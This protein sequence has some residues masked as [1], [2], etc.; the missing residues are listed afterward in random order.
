MSSRSPSREPPTRP[1]TTRTWSRSGSLSGS[2]P[3][4]SRT[5]RATSSSYRGRR[6]R[7]REPLDDPGEGRVWGPRGPHPWS[8]DGDGDG[9]GDGLAPTRLRYEFPITTNG[10]G[11]SVRVNIG[12]LAGGDPDTACSI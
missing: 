10:E 3:R 4:S 9:D 12:E 7:P 1:S 11:Q 8:R 2:G 5:R 6:G